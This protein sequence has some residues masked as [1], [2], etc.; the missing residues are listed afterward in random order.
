M[1]LP[2]THMQ[3]RPPVYQYTRVPVY[4]T[5]PLAFLRCC[6]GEKVVDRREDSFTTMIGDVTTK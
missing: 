5:M 2:P 6:V 4:M 1:S 3:A